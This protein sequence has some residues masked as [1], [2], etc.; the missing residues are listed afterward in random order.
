MCIYKKWIWFLGLALATAPQAF[1][2]QAG[3]VIK[4]VPVIT[5]PQSLGEYTL[6]PGSLRL[7][8]DCDTLL[9]YRVDLDQNSIVFTD[10]AGCDSVTL[11]YRVLSVNLTKPQSLRSITAYDSL[12][13]FKEQ[14]YGSQEYLTERKE[15]LF[16]LGG[17]QKTGNITRGI[18]FGNT[19]DVFVNSL[20]N[21]QLE[22]RISDDLTLTAAI[23]DQNVPFQPEGNTQQ[24]QEFDRVYIQLDHNKGRLTAGDL[25]M[26]N[27]EGHF[28]RYFKNVQGGQFTVRSK[29]WSGQKAETTA[30]AA[31]AKGKFSSQVVPVI[32]GVLGPYRLRG[33]N[34][35]RFIIVI[36]NSEKVFL[37]GKQLIR[38]FDYD[39]VIDYNQGEI[40]FSNRILIT[41]FSRVRVDFEFAE[42]NYS[43]TITQAA[44]Y[45]QSEKVDLY[46]N[47]YREAD[48][49][50]NPLT[51]ELSEEDKIRL[52]A[53]GDNLLNA[54]GSGIDST[55]FIERQVMYRR[56][57]SLVVGQLYQVFVYDTDPASAV[58]RLSFTEVGV[59]KGNYVLAQ[60]LASGRVYRWV[61]PVAGIAQGNFEPLR[62]LPTPKELGMATLGVV[63]RSGKNHQFFAEAAASRNDLNRFSDLDAGDD[64]GTAIKAGYQSQA[65]V[66][67]GRGYQFSGLINAEFNQKNFRFVDRL[68]SIEFD[69]DWSA[70]PKSTGYLADEHIGQASLLIQKDPSNRLMFESIFRQRGSE[71]NGMQQKLNLNKSWWRFQQGTELFYMSNDQGKQYSRWLRLSQDLHLRGKWIVPGYQYQIDQ[72]VVRNRATDSVLFTAMNFEE[73]RIYLRSADS[74]SFMYLADYAIRY[75]QAPLEGRLQRANRSE[76]ANFRLRS[77][78]L[79]SQEVN[80]TFTY[81]KL[82]TLTQSSNQRAEET[83]MGRFDWLGSFFKQSLRTELTY[84][85]GTGRE[86]RREFVYLAVPIGEGTHF[87]RDLNGNNVQEL[88]E[89]FPA[90]TSD[91]RQ[92]IRLF[93]P[94]DEYITAYTNSLIYRLTYNLP[95]SWR[96]KGWFKKQFSKLSTVSSISLENRVTNP[97]P[98]FRY[99]P[100][101]AM[102]TSQSGLLSRTQNT[103]ATVFYNRSNPS[104]GA[105]LAWSRVEQRNLITGGFE[106]RAISEQRIGLR[107]NLASRWNSQTHV[108]WQQRNSESDVLTARNF[109]IDNRELGEELSYQP[110]N[111][112][113]LSLLGTLAERKGQ[114]ASFEN[115][116]ATVQRLGIEA[117][118]NQ[119]L[120]RSIALGINYVNIQFQGQSNN[121]LGVELLEALLPGNNFTWTMNWQQKLTNGLQLNMNYEGRKSGDAPIVHIGRMQVSALF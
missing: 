71:V 35:E 73:H 113:R 9:K 102:S 19:Q 89:F 65:P 61:A 91:Q 55:G 79:K 41:Q 83:I 66:S 105:D 4:K 28:L 45:Q 47:I 86:L 50:R 90:V 116:S 11:S 6:V 56:V 68:R 114:T 87:W 57:D 37:D 51:T 112:L 88:D 96:T 106:G 94:T 54:F 7:I 44:H 21:L 40:T 82:E 74:S 52:R 103:R 43:R 95:S 107:R 1:A 27:R 12:P 42:R 110:G 31:I 111:V 32:E 109:S 69:R 97:L 2:Q 53:S 58:F 104:Y 22:G 85:L 34:N 77:T 84:A 26:K 80:T 121:A 117:K 72:N 20:L 36:A 92:F 101:V 60:T 8:S 46:F 39:Y 23:S 13:V 64:Q 16:G 10:P 119:V 115:S 93:V 99:N 59:G 81:R 3:I 78:S 100:F 120:K 38:G 63:L 98:E 33:P 24:L 17:L 15:E 30:G 5:F 118:I 49:P 75:D 76:T 67:I 108:G 18:S 14:A 29:P 48:N 25:V 62:L 70:D